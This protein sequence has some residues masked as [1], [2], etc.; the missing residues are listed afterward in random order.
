MRGA[1][2][3]AGNP[4]ACGPS[5]YGVVGCHTGLPIHAKNALLAAHP[6]HMLTS[7]LHH[8]SSRLPLMQLWRIVSIRHQPP[9]TSFPI[10]G[11]LDRTSHR[12]GQAG[13]FRHG[14]LDS[15]RV[16]GAARK[17]CL[18]TLSQTPKTRCSHSCSE[19]ES[20]LRIPVSTQRLEDTQRVAPWLHRS[21]CRRPLQIRP[22][23]VATTTLHRRKR[24]AQKEAARL[25]P[26]DLLVS[27]CP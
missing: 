15:T 18:Q 14:R 13:R 9:P 8:R 5:G 27:A 7:T 16:A 6:Q 4:G 12:Q 17:L 3:R 23:I 21:P 10:R 11:S 26:V 20:L 2:S 22:A 25:P 1:A 24:P 19:L